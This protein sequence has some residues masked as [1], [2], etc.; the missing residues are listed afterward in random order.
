[1]SVPKFSGRGNFNHN[2]RIYQIYRKGIIFQRK[3]QNNRFANIV[4]DDVI[5]SVFDFLNVWILAVLNHLDSHLRSKKWWLPHS[6]LL[7]RRKGPFVSY[8]CKAREVGM[9]SGCWLF[10]VFSAGRRGSQD[11]SGFAFIRF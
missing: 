11:S 5:Q 6:W 3:L 4:N 10:L 9:G 1:M 2:F 7:H 8:K